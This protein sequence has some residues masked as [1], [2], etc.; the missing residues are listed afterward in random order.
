VANVRT[1]FGRVNLA[2][3]VGAVLV[4]RAVLDIA[5]V[6]RESGVVALVQAVRNLAAR[7][8][9]LLGDSRLSIRKLLASWISRIREIARVVLAGVFAIAN[10][11]NPRRIR[12]AIRINT[13]TLRTLLSVCV[14]D[15]CVAPACEIIAKSNRY[16][17]KLSV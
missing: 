14:D 17:K 7:L 10:V 11:A 3:R 4:G 5:L 12:L 2:V 8:A 13:S 6:A 9:L 16:K 15:R 1:W